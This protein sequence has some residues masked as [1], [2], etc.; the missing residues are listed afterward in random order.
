MAFTMPGFAHVS[1]RELAQIMTFIRNGWGNR[2]SAVSADDIARMRRVVADK[3]VH[4]LPEES[5]Q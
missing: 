3:P 2:A 1:N 5:A 4:Y